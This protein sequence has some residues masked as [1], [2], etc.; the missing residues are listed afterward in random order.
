VL[1][2]IT[3]ANMTPLDAVPTTP[4][5]S[6]RCGSPGS[7]ACQGKQF[8]LQNLTIGRDTAP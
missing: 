6:S 7:L 8:N 5:L 2:L 3:Y 1:G 4:D